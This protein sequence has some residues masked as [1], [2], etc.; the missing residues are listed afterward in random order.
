[1]KSFIN[2]KAFA[3]QMKKEL[4]SIEIRVL[5]KE[6]QRINGSYINKIYHPEKKTI[7]LS[8]RT[9]EGKNNLYIKLPFVWLSTKR[10]E[11]PEKISGFC[12]L[13]RK[14]L[15][16]SRIASIN[17]IESERIIEIKFRKGEKE[18][19][20]FVEL[21]GEGNIIICDK[22]KEIIAPLEQ[23]E[24]KDRKII[25]GEKYE[26][27]PAKENIFT[28]SMDEFKKKMNDSEAVSKNMA[29]FGAGSVYAEEICLRSGIDK[30]KTNLS[31]KEKEKIFSAFKNMLNE[32]INPRA[33]YENGETKDIVPYSMNIYSQKEQ[34]RF[35]SFTDAIEN[36]FMKEEK[37]EQKTKKTSKHEE[38]ILKTKNIIQIQQRSLVE[39]EK[40]IKE[41]QEKGDYIYN[42]YEKV[43]KILD[44]L[45]KTRREKGYEGLK[46]KTIKVNEQKGEV[47]I[48]I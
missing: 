28:L 24:W 34:K 4:S 16:N 22:E 8:L 31:E 27:P 44:E 45:N 42:N 11:M 29:M 2:I 43:K 40:N 35:N 48:N 1:M 17:Q 39:L 37:K 14:Y 13:L 23:Q 9:S 47:V 6:L 3:T 36:E 38:R 5:I 18:Y 19:K 32:E 7:V 21:F 20:L 30:K 26:L 15:E 10:I 12:G 46:E 41:L 25:A 33:V